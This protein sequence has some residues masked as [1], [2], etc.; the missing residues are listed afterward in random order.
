[1][2]LSYGDIYYYDGDKYELVNDDGEPTFEQCDVR[3]YYEKIEEGEE[4]MID[5]E[6][7]RL[8]DYGGLPNLEI[9]TFN[10]LIKFIEI[11]TDQ[12]P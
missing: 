10:I 5:D 7:Y 3:G 12:T 2:E 11:I 1:M 9:K 8:E 6:T 4:Y